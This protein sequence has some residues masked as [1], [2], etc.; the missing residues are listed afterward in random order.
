MKQEDDIRDDEIRVIGSAEDSGGGRRRRPKTLEIAC[1]ILAL[2]AVAAGLYLLWGGDSGMDAD[3]EN[4]HALFDPAPEEADT[5]KLLTLLSRERTDSLTDGFAERRDT[6]INDIP[7][8]VFIPHNAVPS[9]HV[10][11]LDPADTTIVFA[12][13]AADIRADN[14][15]IVG[16]YVLNGKPLA[17]GL[18]K[19]GYCALIDGEVIVGVADNSPLFERATEC[20]GSFFRQYALVDNGRLVEN[21][22]KNKSIRR[23]LCDRRGEIMVVSSLTPESFHDFAQA[24]VDLGVDRAIYLVG[25]SSYGWWVPRDGVRR[26]FGNSAPRR[27]FHRNTNYILWRRADRLKAVAESGPNGGGAVVEP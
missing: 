22:P 18:S 24:L 10:G 14:G 21:E 20:G 1:L 5:A 23:A 17:W 16:A 9:L 6:V 4:R 3:D 11:R 2:M 15:G 27:R 13:Q 26:E 7:L 19:R 12:A 25:S 8:A